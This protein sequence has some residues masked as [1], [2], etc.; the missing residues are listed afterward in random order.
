MTFS[1]LLLVSSALSALASPI[2]RS[3][4]ALATVYTHCVENNTVALTFDDG[5]YRFEQALINTLNS[6]GIKATFFVNG[7]NWDCI[8]GSGVVASLKSAYASGHQIGAHTWSHPHLTTL[9]QSRIE[10]EFSQI[11]LAL[12]RIVGVLPAF[13]R[14]PYGEYNDLVRQVSH[15]H[16]QAMVTWDFDSGDSVGKTAAQS[17]ALYKQLAEQRPHNVLTLNHETYSSTVYTVLPYAISV[18]KPKG[19]NFVTVAEC[20]GNKTPYQSIKPAQSRTSAWHC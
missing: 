11:E 3:A 20:L 12:E 19:Y 10:S 14:P 16:G 1:L 18:L 9:N 8:Y 15:E 6:H 7:N 4:P 5:P 2:E 17:E 13:M